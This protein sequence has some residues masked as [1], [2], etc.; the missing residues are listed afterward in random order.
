MSINEFLKKQEKQPNEN[1]NQTFES[2]ASEDIKGKIIP[3][4]KRTFSTFSSL[5][6]SQLQHLLPSCTF[7][8]GRREESEQGGEA[9]QVGSHSLQW[10]FQG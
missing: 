5:L 9:V 3:L 2:A 6:F 7:I 4:V 1:K 10:G 8:S